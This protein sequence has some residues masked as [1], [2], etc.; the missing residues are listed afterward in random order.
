MEHGI[1]SIDRKMSKEKAALV[2]LIKQKLNDTK[3]G[4]H[5]KQVFIPRGWACVHIETF[6]KELAS[7]IKRSKNGR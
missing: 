6:A 1:L 4:C 3:K 7:W 5:F 2:R